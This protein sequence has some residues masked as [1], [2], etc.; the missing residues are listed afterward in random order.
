MPLATEPEGRGTINL[1][2]DTTCSNVNMR[3]PAHGIAFSVFLTLITLGT[4]NSSF[5]THTERDWL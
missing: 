1:P 3:L 5:C 4:M 2:M